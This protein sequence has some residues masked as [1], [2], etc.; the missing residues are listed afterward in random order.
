MRHYFLNFILLCLIANP[1]RGQKI[2]QGMVRDAESGQSLPSAN[3][4]IVGTF[5]GTISND[6][7][8][9]ILKIE[10]LP[11]TIAVTYIGYASSRIRIT[12]ASN[13]IQNFSLIP[14]A[15]QLDPIVVTGEDPA[16]RIMREVIK[17]KR[18]WR[19]SLQTYQADGYTR[20]VLENDTSI[21]SIME[22]ISIAFWDREKGVR[23]VIKSRRQTSNLSVK[24]NFALASII[25]NLYD[26]D[27]EMAGFRII[28]VTHPDALKHYDFRLIGQRKR[29]EKIVYDISV[30]PK[31]KLQ[32]TFSG[33]IAVL[34]EDFAMLEVDLR[35]S[36]AVLFPPPIQNFNLHYQQQFHNF[37]TEHWL[38]VDVRVTGGI[39]IGF[40]G[41]S[42]P[43]II[44]RRITT[45]SNYLININL[46]DSLYNEGQ[47][48]VVDSTTISKNVDS[49]FSEN[50]EVVPFTATEKEAYIT[51][52][53]TMTLVKAYRPS[54]VL[55]RFVKMEVQNGDNQE[56]ESQNILSG[57]RPLV[58]FDRVDEATLGLKKTISVSKEIGIELYGGYKT[59]QKQ[60]F[61]GTQLQLKSRR[62]QTSIHYSENSATRYISITY[63]QLFTSIHTLL[64]FNDYF[65][66]YWNKKFNF[67]LGYA[68]KKINLR[69][70]IGI[71]LEK[72]SSL[73]KTTD[74]NILGRNII[75]R[76]NP[77]IPEGNLRSFHFRVIV[78]DEY[79][80]LGIIGQNWIELNIEH[81]SPDFLSSDFHFTRYQL[82]ADIRLK[83]FLKR[84]LLPNVLDIHLVAGSFEGDLPLQKY[85]ILD[86]ALQ[87]FGPFTTFKSL[88][89]QGY[90][91]EKYFGIFWEHNFRTVPFELFG[92]HNIAKKYINIIV[93][94]ASGRSWIKEE[95]L[96]NLNYLPSYTDKFHH[97]MG[98]SISGIFQFLR[99]DITHR[100]DKPN[101]YF[102]IA[103]AR[104]F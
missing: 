76:E 34:D 11:A 103:L 54:G 59:G 40:V 51:L 72:H 43:R 92:L 58:S 12:T 97:E 55:A 48:F 89:G 1:V 101:T 29:D 26:D 95:T 93:H 80:P 49:T 69:T 57:I 84:R 37:G 9:Y 64:G 71:N 18:I 83:T 45:L 33:T 99:F 46:P 56:K 25:S 38:P 13:T 70:L 85:G 78:G 61:Y 23:E 96:V 35:P 90:E 21:T 2:I 20:V 91:G 98:L 19:E 94:G 63:P 41:L 62:W 30:T 66:F 50:P 22:S 42:F 81:S 6:I 87:I 28:G 32:P 102:G 39:K 15:Y 10:E 8:E 79:I 5:R 100:L 88:I 74:Y 75:Q 73:G 67:R 104:F 7:G 24:E 65:D 16:L 68:L 86:G 53:S 44:I 14:I 27:I 17:R 47:I 31:S 36:E 82:N 77:A 52:D 4:Q 60:W 3:I